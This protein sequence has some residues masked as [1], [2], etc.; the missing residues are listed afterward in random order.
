MTER[1][2]PD[3]SRS[4]AFRFDL[5][6]RRLTAIFVALLAWAG[7]FPV[8]VSAEG[9][10]AEQP[11]HIVQL[12][13]LNGTFRAGRETADQVAGQLR[14]ANPSMPAEVWTRF[15]QLVSDRDTLI[16]LYV[17]IYSRHLSDED[18]T[19]VLSFYTSPLGSRWREVLPLIAA[20]T[21]QD[22]QQFIADVA[23]ELGEEGGETQVEGSK[24]GSNQLPGPRARDVEQL[25]RDSGAL[26]Q[27]RVA[28]TDMLERIRNHGFAPDLPNSF[29]QSAQNKMTDE[30]ALL[31]LWTPAYARHLDAADVTALVAFYQSSLGER[32]VEAQA[33]IQ[34]ESVDAATQLSN[35]SARQAVREVLGPLP[36]WRL[37]NPA[38]PGKP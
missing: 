4:T 33:A 16:E 28:M 32:F 1:D 7:G 31:R 22:A 14:I 10:A 23:L 26:S 12:L 35:R 18:V 27:A 37:Q 25:L 30:N 36:Q 11:A 13:E 21:R 24:T 29:W 5:V 19:A 15:S 8:G 17:P 9:L 38:E 6:R 3:V 2:P 20:D 34:K